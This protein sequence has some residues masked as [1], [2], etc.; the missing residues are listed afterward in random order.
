MLTRVWNYAKK[1]PRSLRVLYG[2]VCTGNV[3]PIA[4]SRLCIL[5]FVTRSILE[6]NNEN[7]FRLLTWPTFRTTFTHGQRTRTGSRIGAVYIFHTYDRATPLEMS[8]F[9]TG[10]LLELCIRIE[11][12]FYY[13]CW[14]FWQRFG[15]VIVINHTDTHT[16]THQRRFGRTVLLCEQVDVLTK[17]CTYVM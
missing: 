5:T 1:S 14:M 16:H 12:V 4:R 7:I 2:V 10:V 3:E 8:V 13:K 11:H 6:W 17:F 15:K 9:V